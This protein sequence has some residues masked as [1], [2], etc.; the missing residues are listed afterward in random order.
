MTTGSGERFTYLRSTGV[1]VLSATMTEFAYKRHAHEDY[2]LGVTL[3]GLQEYHLEGRLCRSRPGGVILFNPEEVHDGCSAD[4]TSLEY[5]MVYVPR[6]LFA[7]VSGMRGPV[8]FE[9]PIVYDRALAARILKLAR[10]VAA[11]RDE[12]WTSELLLDMVHAALRGRT[13]RTARP[14]MSGPAPGRSAGV[15][16]AMDMM[17]D[18][19][20][21]MTGDG[22]GDG[23]D[24]RLR[25]DDLSREVGMSKY[26]FIRH[27]KA[28]T[29]ISPYQFFLNC[30][31]E[32]AKR[33]LE[34]EGDVYAAVAQ[35]GFCDLSH[36]NR[37]FKRIYGVTASEYAHIR[38]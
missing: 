35:C 7:E 36:L 32:H 26:H 1:T 24:G 2:A 4:R 8:G 13:G 11:G 3:R 22:T 14:L 37:H 17:R 10:G 27:F 16:R 28:A 15:R 21:G 30:K 6:P 34:S 5:V 29:G 31:V 23:A 12:M 20:G 38:F 25:L 18:A 33:L 19:A 9:A